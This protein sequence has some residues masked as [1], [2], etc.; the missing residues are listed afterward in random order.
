VAKQNSKKAT[1]ENTSQPGKL[2][3][4]G[5]QWRSRIL[6]VISADGLRPTTDRVRETVFNWLQNEIAGSRCLDLFAGSGA[7]GFEAASRGAAE[8]VMV[9]QNTTAFQQLKAN[10]QLLKATQVKCCHINALQYLQTPD[11]AGFDIV[12]L[13][14]PYQSDLITVTSQSLNLVAGALVY[15]E[16][17]KDQSPVLPAGW[18]LRKDKTAGQIRYRLFEVATANRG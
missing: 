2:R 15:V 8:V 11:A 13:D 17:R 6:P 18:E 14:P 10:C 16:T 4:I 12:F 7:L 3:I 5:G 1:P 9:E